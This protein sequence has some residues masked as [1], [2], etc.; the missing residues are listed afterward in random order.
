MSPSPDL[1]V[2]VVR[3][4]GRMEQQSKHYGRGWS[5][6]GGGR[7]RGPG[8]G[9]EKSR[10][11]AGKA[12]GGMGMLSLHRAFDAVSWVP[13]PLWTDVSVRSRPRQRPR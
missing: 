1:L 8:R 5:L 7:A 11:G 6:R 3:G 12:E 9:G 13:L 10:G 4:G 2:A